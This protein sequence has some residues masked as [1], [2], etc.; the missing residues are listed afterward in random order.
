[1][2]NWFS[3]SWKCRSIDHRHRRAKVGLSIAIGYDYLTVIY[4]Q[5]V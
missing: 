4:W 3:Q 5:T 2:F 1:M